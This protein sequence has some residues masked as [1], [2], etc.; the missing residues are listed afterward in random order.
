MTGLQHLAVRGGTLRAAAPSTGDGDHQQQQQEE[1]GEQGEEEGG[2]EVVMSSSS[3]DDS[4]DDRSDEQG[5]AGEEEG[6]E[7]QGPGVGLTVFNRLKQLQHLELSVTVWPT[8]ALCPT[9]ADMAALTASSQLTCLI[10]G[11]MLV[12]HHHYLHMFPKGRL[13]PQLKG[14]Q[15]T[16]SLLG[17][18]KDAAAV[19]RCCPKLEWIDVSTGVWLVWTS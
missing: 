11:D 10:L 3:W 4:W 13:L 6:E 16:M 15:A 14:L 8:M 2:Q 1:E 17:T 5:D 19:V 18:V 9:R 7:D 12:R